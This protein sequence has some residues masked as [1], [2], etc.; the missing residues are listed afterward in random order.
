MGRNRRLPPLA[1]IPEQQLDLL[2]SLNEQYGACTNSEEQYR[3]Q[4][5]YFGHFKNTIRVATTVAAMQ[6]LST[7]PRPDWLERKFASKLV[8]LNRREKKARSKKTTTPPTIK[9]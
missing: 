5:R 2:R 1:V 8:D 3:I 6:Q 4:S 9:V 7:L